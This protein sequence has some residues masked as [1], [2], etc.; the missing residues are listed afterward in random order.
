MGSRNL[1]RAEARA[2]LA[3]YRAVTAA[4]AADPRERDAWIRTQQMIAGYRGRR[5]R[6]GE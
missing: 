6:H 3:T 5:F 1:A 4:H 2:M